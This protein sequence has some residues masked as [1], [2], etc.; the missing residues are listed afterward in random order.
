MWRLYRALRFGEGPIEVLTGLHRWWFSTSIMTENTEQSVLFFMLEHRGELLSF[1]YSLFDTTTRKQGGWNMKQM[2]RRDC[3]SCSK[4]IRDHFARE[5]GDGRAIRTH[6]HEKV[7][8][9][10]MIPPFLRQ[11]ERNLVESRTT[12]VPLGKFVIPEN[13]QLKFWF[14][15]IL[16]SL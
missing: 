9:K 11:V 16:A 8:G 13:S 7:P 12:F 2:A 1:R 5:H 10:E 4:N 15:W 6:Q 3:N 14:L